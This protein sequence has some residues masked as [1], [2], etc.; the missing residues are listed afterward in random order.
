MTQHAVGHFIPSWQI[1]RVVRASPALLCFLG[2]RVF[3]KRCLV[4]VHQTSCIVMFGERSPNITIRNESFD[5]EV[6]NRR[7]HRV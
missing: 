7:I 4:S 6:H 1:S 2:V 3:A 5:F